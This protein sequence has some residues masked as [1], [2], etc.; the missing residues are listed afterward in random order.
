[1]NEKTKKEEIIKI[2]EELPEYFTCDAI[3]QIQKDLVKCGY[4]TENDEKVIGF[5]IYDFKD[6]KCLIKWMAVRKDKQRK[7]IGKKLIEK[8]IDICKKNNI[9]EIEIDTLADTENYKPYEKT[10]GFYH[11][12]GFK[13]VKVI[14]KGY[15]DGDDKLVLGLGV[16]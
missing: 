13:D 6:K 8:L 12:I 16:G 1:M 7:G 3:K 9:K 15:P 10:R 4:M 5:I 2:A 14:K 11:A